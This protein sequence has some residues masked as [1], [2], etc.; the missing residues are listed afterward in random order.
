MK[1]K[2]SDD[3]KVLSIEENDAKTSKKQDINVSNME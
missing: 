3:K 1:I 2:N